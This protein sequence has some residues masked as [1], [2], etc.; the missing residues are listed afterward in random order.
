MSEQVERLARE[1][2]AGGRCWRDLDGD[3]EVSLRIEEYWGRANLVGLYFAGIEF[4]AGDGGG[5][6][7]GLRKRY[8]RKGWKG[9]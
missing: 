2:A 6:G 4:I 5:A 3:A 7:V 8:L 9:D 1:I